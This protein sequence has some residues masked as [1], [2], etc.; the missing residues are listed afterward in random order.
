MRHGQ[1]E[2]SVH[3]RYSGHGD[4]EL[5]PLG[6]AQARG[7]RSSSRAPP[8]SGRSSLGHID[9]V[10]RTLIM[11]FPEDITIRIKPLAGQT[12]IDV[13]SAS[14]YGRNDFGTNAKRIG[15]FA[16]ELQAQ[17]DTK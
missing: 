1:T 3:R 5:T 2:L 10:D 13:R 4:P 16:R 14:R 7:P 11:G 8:G 6:H 15:A 17:L 9:A 12:R